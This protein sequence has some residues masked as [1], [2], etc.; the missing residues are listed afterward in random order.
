EKKEKGLR[1]SAVSKPRKK[2]TKKL[3][4]NEKRELDQIEKNISELEE[5]KSEL[6]NKIETEAANL[7]HTEF[8]EISSELEKI[9]KNLN[10]L[11][12][13]WLELEEK[14]EN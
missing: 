13:R 10:K 14:N 12:E 1:K 8:A 3:S 7:S 6:E 11:T 2:E 9:E 4:F 5:R